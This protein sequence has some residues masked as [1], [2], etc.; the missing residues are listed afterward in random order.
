MEP[1]V[2]PAG[3]LKG[4]FAGWLALVGVVSAR[5]SLPWLSTPPEAFPSLHQLAS[6][7]HLAL[8]FFLPVVTHSPGLTSW[9]PPKIRLPLTITM[10]SKQSH[11]MSRISSVDMP[12]PTQLPPS[13]AERP[14][15][16]EVPGLALSAVL[17]KFASPPID[18]EIRSSS[19]I[20]I[21]EMCWCG[22]RPTL[23]TL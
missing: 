1:K 22:R 5:F 2:E 16:S 6:A 8:F 14:L 11:R 23:S 20:C 9:I 10:I 19:S 21:D 4:K 12:L 17:L 15:L 7:V 13:L 18:T 3:N